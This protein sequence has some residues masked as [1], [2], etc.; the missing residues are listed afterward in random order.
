MKQKQKFSITRTLEGTVFEIAFLVLAIV[1]WAVIIV[2]MR[3]A[4]D[5]IATHFN[6][7]GNPDSYGNKLNILF[8]LIITTVAGACS[9]LGAYFPH[10]VNLPVKIGNMRQALLVTRM[11][12]ILSIAFLLL[13]LAIA[14]SSLHGNPSAVPAIA[15][16]V[17]IIGIVAIFT[18]LVYRSR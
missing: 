15:S 12:R 1:V 2:M 3:H 14:Y 4:P 16:V 6:A 9:L 10:T 17:I 8:P 18:F 5:I 11:M 7:A 13:T